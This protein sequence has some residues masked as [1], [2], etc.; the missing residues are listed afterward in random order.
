MARK[1][2]KQVVLITGA[3]GGIGTATAD[4]LLAKGYTVYGTTRNLDSA[5]KTRYNNLQLDV[6]DAN[7]VKNCIQELMNK[8]E[9]IDIL[10]NNAGYGLCGA[11]KDLT[12]EEIQENFD[13]NLFGTHRMVKEIVPIMIRQGK[14]RIINIGTFGG[15]LGLPFQGIYSASKA[16]LAVYSDALKIELLRD[17]IQVSLIEPGDIK[18]D[19]NAGRKFADGYGEDQD[20]QRAVRIMHEAEQKGTE[21]QKVAK[22]IY[23]A[24]KARRPK[25]RYTRGPDTKFFGTL[26]RLLPYT[27]HSFIARLYYGVPKKRKS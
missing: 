13:T 3:S 2:E 20:A 10:V 12:I 18:T 27:L 5:P 26:M 1:K 22:T 17:N 6:Q 21:P 19:F 24:I 23:R 16:A 8:E 9:K 4:L 14:G 15:R 25:P 11:I 7:S